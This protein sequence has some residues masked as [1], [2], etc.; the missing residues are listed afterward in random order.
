MFSSTHIPANSWVLDTGAM[1]HM[2]CNINYM[3]SVQLLESPLHVKFPTGEQAVVTHIGSVYLHHLSLSITEVFYI[4]SF[5]FNLLYVSKL[6]TQLQSTILFTSTTYYLR[7]QCQK[8]GL[9]LGN[10]LD[11][12]YQLLNM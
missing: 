4:P 8:K 2:C 6:S 3:H 11:S 5:T 7:D 12:L 9:V 1:N 10:I